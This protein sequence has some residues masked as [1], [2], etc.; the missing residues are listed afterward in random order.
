VL[1]G[2]FD[3]PHVGHLILASE[4]AWQLRLDEVR[5]VV[6]ARPPHREAG[7]L[8]PELRLRLAEA[9]AAG[10][11]S[12][13]ASRAEID[14]PGPNYMVDTLGAF[15][16][17]EP[18]T[19]FWL[20]LGADQLAAFARWHRPEDIVAIARLGVAARNDIDRHDLQAVANEVAPDRVDWIDMPE[21]D[22]SSTV[23]RDRIAAGTPVR[24]LVT[25]PVDDVLVAEGL[26]K[27]P[28]PLP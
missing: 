28:N 1:G 22:V 4:A 20:L 21:V 14:R 18:G 24:H 6:T 3:P 19:V 5:L 8:A 27:R 13:R 16:A 26:S 9:L 2:M 25:P 10:F 17:A 7:W 23:I 15:A 12:L 11:P